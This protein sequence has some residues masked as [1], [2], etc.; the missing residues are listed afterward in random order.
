[1]LTR[2][3]WAALLTIGFGV[4]LVIMDATIVN[5]A[6]PVVIE[7]L[8]LTA[9][10]AQWMNAVYSLVFA[11]LLITVGRIGD[12]EGRRLLFLIGMVVF[13]L[14]SVVAGLSVN[15]PMLI[16][17]RFV[18]GIGAA[19]I[20]PST[21]SSLN[22]LFVGHARVI[23]FAVYGSAIGGMAALGPLLGGWLATDYSWRWAFWLN[24]PVGLLVVVGIVRALPETRDPKATPSRDLLGVAMFGMG[25]IVFGLMEAETHGWWR[26]DTGSLSPVPFVLAAG[27]LSMVAFVL[28][29]RRR[30][31]A[32]IPVLVDLTLFPIPT[33]SAGAAAALIVA[34]GEFGL[35][36]TLPLLLQ[37]TLG[38]TAL[39]TGWVIVALAL[40]TFLVSGALPQISRFLPHRTVVQIGL[41]LEAAAVGAL[42]RI[43]SMDVTAWQLCACLFVHGLG[44]GMATAQLTSLLVHDVPVDESGQASGLQSTVRQ[45]GSALGVAV[46]G[47]LLIGSL[48]RTTEASLAALSLPQVP[49]RRR[50]TVCAWC[51]P[52]SRSS[53]STTP[54]A[55]SS[56]RS[57]TW[58]A[59]CSDAPA[60]RCATSPTARCAADPSGTRWSRGCPC[61][62]ASCTA[63]RRAT[64][65]AT[66]GRCPACRRW[67]GCATTVLARC[68]SAPPAWPP[69]VG[70]CPPSSGPCSTPCRSA[71]TLRLR[72][73]PDTRQAGRRAL[74]GTSGCAPTDGQPASDKPCPMLSRLPG[75]AVRPSVGASTSSPATRC[76]RPGGSRW[77]PTGSSGGWTATAWCRPR[78]TTPGS[79][80][81]TTLPGTADRPP[82]PCGSLR[83]DRSTRDCGGP[84]SGYQP[85]PGAMTGRP[86]PSRLSGWP[87]VRSHRVARPCGCPPC[88]LRRN[89]SGPDS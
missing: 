79:A 23:A 43:I 54:M 30:A 7:D 47:G 24:I 21:L 80:H 86:G 14:A 41:A 15:G 74:R 50:V 18:Q 40:G 5:V 89:A 46:L 8:S 62:C 78:R 57:A 32:G 12:L 59:T 85:P 68:C 45:L 55:G 10:E 82:P 11:A 52:W 64:T 66:P 48:G 19:M 77:G 67:S 25:A 1:M 42:A 65:T 27:V 33:F 61:R 34:F 70:R 37:G 35:L 20:L 69:S 29:E 3:D 49:P 84:V 13:M 63:T 87:S 56:V 83:H 9:T 38:Y 53:V 17:A 2:R 58:W 76:G 39:Q 28:H 44:V 6:L 81:P 22:A 31:R 36:F 88:R 51:S 4:S 16:A 73:A 75:P 71:E 60:A 72:K 26:T